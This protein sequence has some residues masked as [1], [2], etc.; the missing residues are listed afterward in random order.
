MDH[1]PA[2][3]A[4]GQDDKASSRTNPQSNQSASTTQAAPVP[5]AN[6]IPQGDLSNL[7][8]PPELP[9]DLH[10][11]MM[12]H[13]GSM[14]GADA[15]M[16][17]PMMMP[18]AFGGMDG[19]MDAHG[20]LN[21]PHLPQNGISNGN[22]PRAYI[23]NPTVW[24]AHTWADEIALYDRQIRLWGMQAQQKIRNA[25]VLLI[26][27]KAL[28]NEIA[29][30]LVLAGIGSLTI[31][32]H[33]NVTEAD[34]GAQF[35]L[36]EEEG[37]LGMNR[38]QAAVPQVQKLNPRVNVIADTDD[39]RFKGAS[40][41]ALF[42][43]VIATDLDPAA[44]NIINTATRL[45]MRPFYAAGTHGLYGFIFADLIE[46][47]FVIE[48][49]KPNVP[50]EPKAET[51]TRIIFDVQTKKENGKTIEMVSKKELYSTWLL[52][53]DG[54]FLPE[55]YTKS[56]R[57]LRAVNPTLSC[58]R[59]LW[60]FQQTHSGRNPGPNQ[61]DLANFTKL[62]TQKH[63]DLSLPT[64]T[65]TAELLRSFLQNIG[66]EIA[67]VTAILGGQ[68]AQDAI[69]VLGQT[70]QPIQNMVIFDGNT[71]EASLYPLHPQGPLGNQLLSMGGIPGLSGM[72]NGDMH[73]LMNDPSLMNMALPPMD[74]NFSA[75]GLGAGDAQQ[76][77][78]GSETGTAS[79]TG[80]ART[81]FLAP[82]TGADG[83]QQ[84]GQ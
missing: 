79:G 57:R 40:Y 13:D 12:P 33:E 51:R 26:T 68:L 76:H 37:H 11:F 18:M 49:E 53:S 36:S 84:R 44:L 45:N 43:M 10:S 48:R 19:S 17:M 80:E 78:A 52:A 29:K 5:N 21:M 56:K 73:G 38:A 31:I 64:E 16:N 55:E 50:T 35:F 46:H 82:N 6:A 54:A 65:L 67:P 83:T 70:Q 71:M 63:K 39:V 72:G 61:N 75:H 34:L 1:A 14:L 58:L 15:L 23:G 47:T 4:Q 7:T 41:F 30:N 20:L 24:Y 42:D 77:F 60:E 66:C 3:T 2:A 69:N 22:F 32:D 9:A 81:H 59:A 62:A 8:L 25:N 28:A 74:M 27:M